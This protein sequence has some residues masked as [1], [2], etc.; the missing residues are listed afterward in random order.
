MGKR[1]FRPFP[2]SR[3]YPLF[4]YLREGG[5]PGLCRAAV[6]AVIKG[7]D[8]NAGEKSA[9]AYVRPQAGGRK[10]NMQSGAL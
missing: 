6:R 1:T 3:S 4:P 9:K 7:A 10:I 5:S 8:V 2:H